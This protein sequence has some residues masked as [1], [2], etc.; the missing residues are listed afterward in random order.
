MVIQQR[1]KYGADLCGTPLRG[2]EVL[3]IELDVVVRRNKAEAS[4]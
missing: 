2:V 4:R 1:Q 3:D